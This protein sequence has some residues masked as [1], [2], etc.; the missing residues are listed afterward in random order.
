MYNVLA[1]EGIAEAVD[2]EY[3]IFLAK[4]NSEENR[5]ELIKFDKK[6]KKEHPGVYNAC[7]RKSVWLLRKS[8][9]K[10][11]PFA[12]WLYSRMKKK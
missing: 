10:L 7:K 5:N 4:G 12:A 1:E 6:L 3:Q 8:R 2:D 11:F 9:F